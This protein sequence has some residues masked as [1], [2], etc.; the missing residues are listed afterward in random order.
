MTFLELARRLALECG[1]TASASIPAAVTSQTGNLLKAVNWL[2]DAWNELQTSNDNWRWM[3][4]RFTLPTVASTSEYAYTDATDVIASATISRFARWIVMDPYNPPK[5]YLT[6][7]G[8]GSQYHLGFLSWED[9]QQVYRI[10]TEQEGPPVHVTIDPQ[11][12]LVFGPTP[13]DIYTITGEYQKSPQILAANGDTPELP[14][15]FHM[16]LVYEAMR[17][18]ANDQVAQEVMN[19]AVTQGNRLLSMLQLDQL[20]AP[21]VGGPL[22]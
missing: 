10:G 5:A 1:M 8:I 17:I 9:F 11:N 14:A 19:R 3:R 15:R 20:P 12:N 21:R 7:S 13:N 18:Y 22:A 6:S 2:G 16:L 4:S